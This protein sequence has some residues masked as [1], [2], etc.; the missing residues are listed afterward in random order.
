MSTKRKRVMITIEEKWEAITRFKNGEILRTMAVDLGVGV[1]VV[2]DWVKM[3]SMLLRCQQ[4]NNEDMS[5]NKKVHEPVLLWS[6][7]Q[8]DDED[9]DI[10][11]SSSHDT[12]LLYTS[13]CV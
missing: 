11:E 6:T 2:S 8:R 7:Q 1:L 10:T 5:Q 13:R 3:K 9:D 4:E 12:C